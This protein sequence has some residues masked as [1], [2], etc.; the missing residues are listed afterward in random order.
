MTASPATTTAA[1]ASAPPPLRRRAPAVRRW[2]TSYALLAPALLLFGVF[3]LYPLVGA[4]RISLTDSS[5]IG[6]ARFVG[7]DNYA[8]MAG[9]AT[10]WRAALNT[11]LLAAVSVP[12]SLLL[13][14]GVALLLR[15][16]IP[17]GG[18]FRAVFLAP[19]VISGVVVAMTGRWLF[20]QNVGIVDRVLGGLGLPAPDWQSDGTAASV[21][22][23]VVLLWARTGL[24]VILYL[25]A[26]QGIDA[27]VLEA[28]ELD[29]ASPRQRLRFVAWPLLRPT[30]FFL[31]VMLVI[32]TF[33]VFDI[34]W[35][36]TRGGPAGATELLV[37]Y[38]YNQGFSARRQGYGSAIG[39]VVFVVVLAATVLWWRAQRRSE[40]EL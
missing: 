38:A 6:E 27:D 13:G 7:L 10:F 32:E 2:A 34:V 24:A 29:G 16:R 28:A 15:D 19:Y 8:A 33:Q 22:V 37:T 20:D 3:V 17:G 1:S 40:E 9:D 14:L 18:L 12:V 21:S 30:T 26:L 4:V 35:V 11:A 36:M 39:V 23:L 31:T 5:G 25:S